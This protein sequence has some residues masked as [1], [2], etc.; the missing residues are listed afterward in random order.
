MSGK[1]GGN[2][3]IGIEVYELI[4]RIILEVVA[5]GYLLSQ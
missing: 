5:V 4:C 3:L 2:K 1:L